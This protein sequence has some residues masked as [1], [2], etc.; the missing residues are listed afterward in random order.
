VSAHQLT[1]GQ[2]R[3]IVVRAQLLDADRPGDVVEVAEQLA[4][5]KI[6][7]TAVIAPCEHTVLWS[8]IGWSYEPGQLRKAVEDDRLLFEFEGTFRPMSLLPLLR[9]GMR[10]WPQRESSRR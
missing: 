10:R 6:D 5:I 7:P 2:A 8:R 4:Y 1:R 9:P 3:R